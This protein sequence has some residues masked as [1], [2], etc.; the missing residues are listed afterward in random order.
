MNNANI[1]NTIEAFH[2]SLTS[3]ETQGRNKILAKPSVTF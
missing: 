1:V 2:F 3:T